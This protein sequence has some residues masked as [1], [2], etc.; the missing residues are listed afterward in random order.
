MHAYLASGKRHGRA[1]Q[2]IGTVSCRESRR[3]V[4]RGRDDRHTVIGVKRPR[5]F[6]DH[7]GGAD[8]DNRSLRAENHTS[9]R[10][11]IG[12]RTVA[13]RRVGTQKHRGR[14]HAGQIVAMDSKSNGVRNVQAR[15]R[16]VTLQYQTC[17]LP[18]RVCRLK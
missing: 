7:C 5:H 10:E 1:R 11:A 17:L 16:A 9:D 12:R 13:V 2:E 6:R 14:E 8:V 15:V 18:D 3:A 4:D